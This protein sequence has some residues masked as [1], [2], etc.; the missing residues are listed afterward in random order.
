MKERGDD[1]GLEPSAPPAELVQLG[2]GA[3]P[4]DRAVVRGAGRAYRLGPVRRRDARRSLGRVLR[5]PATDDP[6]RDRFILS[7]G[8]AAL[9]LYCRAGRPR[10]ARRR[11]PSDLLPGRLAA[12]RPSGVRPARRRGLRPARSAR[13]SRS[14]AGSPSRCAAAVRRPA[15][16]CCSA[17]PSA[18][19]G[20]SGRRPCS[21]PIIGS[22][23][24]SPWS[25]S[26]G[27]R[28]WAGPARCSTRPRWPG[29]GGVRLARRRGRRP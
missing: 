28:R 1:Y 8:H 2:A 15:S 19:R 26:T 17:T 25:T 16:S 3:A 22:P 21:R 5:S 18:T 12:R 24:S 9:A 27:C 11:P 29:A 6:D 10:A 14:A 13:G 23:T 20:R 4:G 7:K